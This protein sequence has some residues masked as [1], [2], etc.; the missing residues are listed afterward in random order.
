MGHYYNLKEEK[1]LASTSLHVTTAPSVDEDVLSPSDCT[2]TR[3]HKHWLLIRQLDG[4]CQHYSLYRPIWN[5]CRER[6]TNSNR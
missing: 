2:H 6:G 1:K 4:R 5:L 3:T